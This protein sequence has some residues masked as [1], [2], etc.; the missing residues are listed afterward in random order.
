M[1]AL[2]HTI[3]PGFPMA[4]QSV[5]DPLKIC[6][7]S[8]LFC[9]AAQV[10]GISQRLAARLGLKTAGFTYTTS[11]VMGG[12]KK[13]AFSEKIRL[14][15]FEDCEKPVEIQPIIIPDEYAFF[16]ACIALDFGN[17]YGLHI[18]ST[19]SS[20]P[21][22]TPGPAQMSEN[23]LGAMTM[24]NETFVK[25]LPVTTDEW[26]EINTVGSSAVAR[27]VL[28]KGQKKLVVQYVSGP[29]VY[30][31][32]LGA[33]KTEF[34]NSAVFNI[35][36]D[37]FELFQTQFAE[38]EGQGKLTLGQAISAIKEYCPEPTVRNPPGQK[39]RRGQRTWPENPVVMLGNANGL[40]R[41]WRDAE[42]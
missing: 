39:K 16:E 15:T 34:T 41:S 23:T 33:A 10:S 7:I 24:Y 11:V 17:V 4:I 40:T 19:D 18:G 32:D 37:K 6:N 31:Y 26:I 21:P 8:V 29:R 14:I 20:S 12:L 36:M 27:V 30:E 5:S 2:P 42:V 13:M 9:T 25:T 28:N 1:A 3:T 38:G 35:L 22:V